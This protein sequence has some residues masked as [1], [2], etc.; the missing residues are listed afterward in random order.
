[1]KSV[2]SCFYSN[3]IHFNYT[4]A[5]ANKNILY[6]FKNSTF[7]TFLALWDAVLHKHQIC[8]LAT[9]TTLSCRLTYYQGCAEKLSTD[10]KEWR[11]AMKWTW[12]ADW[13]W[14]AGTLR[15]QPLWI[16]CSFLSYRQTNVHLWLIYFFQ[17]Y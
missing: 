3:Q 7:M 9:V 16:R 5:V 13:V 4:H 17:V 14:L 8:M 15:S 1:M 11:R 12:L 10:H 6:R 2:I